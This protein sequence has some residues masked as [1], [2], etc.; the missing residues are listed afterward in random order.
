MKNIEATVS[1]EAYARLEKLAAAVN[2][3]DHRELSVNDLAGIVL[4][5]LDQAITRQG[6][7]ERESFTRMFGDD[8]L[9]KANQ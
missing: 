1:A 4:D 9:S 6:S 3:R 7:W 8:V 2:Q 5:G